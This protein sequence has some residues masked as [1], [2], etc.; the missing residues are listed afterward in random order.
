ML[1]CASSCSESLSGT[2]GTS[3]MSSSL[4]EL[5]ELNCCSVH[6]SFLDLLLL[7]SWN[8]RSEDHRQPSHGHNSSSSSS[9]TPAEKITSRGTRAAPHKWLRG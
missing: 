6:V 9:H 4:Q 1:S 2:S 8:D 7:R 3:S 5:G